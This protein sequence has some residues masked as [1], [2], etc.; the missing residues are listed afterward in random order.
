MLSERQYLS[1]IEEKVELY[2][3]VKKYNAALEILER[4]SLRY[5]DAANI[6][7]LK[8]V[9]YHRQSKFADAIKE[10]SSALNKNPEYLEASLNLCITLCD[11]GQNDEAAEIYRSIELKNR[12]RNSIPKVIK[13]KLANSHADNGRAYHKAGMLQEAASEFRKALS[14]YEKMPDINS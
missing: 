9:V 12:S 13:G 5:P 7:M 10:F 8:G 3:R 2:L 6:T 1:N 4:A 11:L 14:L